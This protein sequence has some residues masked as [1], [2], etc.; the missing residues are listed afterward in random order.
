MERQRIY[1][2]R[3]K[4]CGGTTFAMEQEMRVKFKTA[5]DEASAWESVEINA[6]YAHEGFGWELDAFTPKCAHCGAEDSIKVAWREPKTEVEAPDSREQP[7]AGP[8]S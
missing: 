5:E 2:V 8:Q 7:G 3:C 6:V 1:Y 4:A